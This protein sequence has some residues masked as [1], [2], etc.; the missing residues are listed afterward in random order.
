MY[1]RYQSLLFFAVIFTLLNPTISKAS[2]NYIASGRLYFYNYDNALNPIRFARIVLY[3]INGTTKREVCR[4]YTTYIGEFSCRFTWN[5]V[6]GPDI[7]YFVF[8]TDDRSVYVANDNEVA[9]RESITYLA[10][11]PIIN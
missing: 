5:E 6:D 1:R 2:T 8:A 4:T 10:E 11:S 9:D 3:E 7:Q